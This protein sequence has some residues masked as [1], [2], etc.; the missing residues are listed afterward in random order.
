M[1]RKGPHDQ[2]PSRRRFGR[3]LILTFF[4]FHGEPVEAGSGIQT[5]GDILQFVLP[6][7]AAT[8]DGKWYG[9]K[10]SRKF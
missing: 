5:R 3:L 6:A 4:W 10:L 2:C 8:A 1:N 9:F 7:G